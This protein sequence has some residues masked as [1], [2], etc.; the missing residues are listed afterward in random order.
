V[1]QALIAQRS[2][3]SGVGSAAV[4]SWFSDIPIFDYRA[5]RIALIELLIDLGLLVAI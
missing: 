3:H 4:L 2:V 1:P 5:E